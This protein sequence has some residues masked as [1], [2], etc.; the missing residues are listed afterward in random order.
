M[1]AE[2]RVVK[3]TLEPT[4]PFDLG[5]SIAFIEGFTPCAGDHVCSRQTVTTGGYVDDA[6]FTVRVSDNEDRTLVAE[7]D[8]VES[9]GDPAAVED[10]LTAFLSLDDDLRDLYETGRADES[11]RPVLR[12]L[13]GYHHVR[14]PTPF[15]AA[16]WAALSQ[17]TPM[18][19]ARRYKQDLIGVAGETV[20]VDGSE[21]SLFPTPTA[22]REA[23]AAVST[24]IDNERKTKTILS[25][26]ECFTH[27]SLDDLSDTEL[28]DRLAD[29]W[30][31]G[32]W[33]SEF[34]ALRGFG[35]LSGLPRT[36]RRLREA[37]GELYD[38]DAPATDDD[39]DRLSAPYDPHAGYWAHYIRVGAF[40]QSQSTA[41]D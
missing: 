40:Q 7:I 30:G 16:C 12:D 24:V 20:S 25:A 22:V 5:K 33:S 15:E 28:R 17:R 10:W 13:H 37:V 29:I 31:F 2:P 23:A 19:V 36:E 34:V 39:L 1:E 21:I 11:F 26:A 32:D 8:W 41:V 27:E 3:R 38:L 4:Q 35:R 18:N 14:F 9:P 6:P